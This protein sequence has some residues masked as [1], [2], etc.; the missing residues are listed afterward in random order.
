MTFDLFGPLPTGTTVLE[1]SAGTGKTYTIVGL[2]TR[3]VA[4]GV[5]SISDLLLVTFSRAATLELRERTRE[6]FTATATALADPAG[7]REHP[8]GVVRHLATGTDEDVRERRERLVS[9]LAD[10]DAGT[11]VTTHSFCQRM[12]DGLGVAGDRAPD[13]QFVETVDD[14]VAEV[15]GDIYLRAY[16]KSDVVPFSEKDALALARD[17]VG[18]A[19]SILEP[20][21]DRETEWG[22]RVLFADAVRREVSARKQRGGIRD[23][24]DLLVLLHAVVSDPESGESACRRIRERYRVVL[25]DEFQ[26]TDPLQWDILRRAFHEHTTLVLVGDP[27]QAIYA[28]R[29]AEVLSYLDAVRH[30]GTHAELTANW[31]TDAPLVGALE[32]VY[33]GAALGHPEIVVRPVLAVRTESA[34]PGGAPLQIRVLPR[35]AARARP[36]PNGFPPVA[37]MRSA[38]ASDVASAMLAFLRSGAT[39]ERNGVARS[40]EPGDIAVLVR[41]RNQ[42][43]LVR[44]ALDE[45]GIPSV[46]AGGTSVFATRS[47]REWSWVLRALEQPYRA[48]RVRLAALTPLFGWSAADLDEHRD[49]ALALIG[50]ELR[51]LAALFESTGFAAVFETLSARSRLD[52]RMLAEVAGERALTDLRHIAQVLGRVALENDYGV[53][54][55]ARWLGERIDE[56]TMG[57]TGD[58]S[59]RLDSDAAAVQIATVHASKGLEFPIVYVPFAWDAARH[60]K[61][62]TL[63]LHSEDGRRVLD[64]GGPTAP[65]YRERRSRAEAEESGEELR[66]LYVALTRAKS[67]VVAWWA[68]VSAT[69]R[70]ALQRV[71][72]GRAAG[73]PDV[74]ASAP[75]PDDRAVAQ[76]FAARVAD[77][78][79][80]IEVVAGGAPRDDDA[81]W[82]SGGTGDDALT[83]AVFTRTLDTAWRRTSYSALTAAAHDAPVS[84]PEV[85]QKTDEPEEAD[86][87]APRV[88]ADDV[89]DAIPSPLNDFPGGT[90]FGT[91]VHEILEYVDTSAA[92]LATELTTHCR[93]AVAAHLA[94]VDPDALATGL[95][96]VLHT[97]LGL[98]WA[99]G[100][101]LADV[102]PRDRLAELDFEL[103]LAGGLVPTHGVVDLG[104]VAATLRRRLPGTDVL[105]HYADALDALDTA[106]IRGFLTGSIDAVLRVGGRFVVVDY[107]TNRLA[108]DELTTA[109]YTRDRMTEAMVHSHYPLQALIYSVALHR[110]LRQRLPGY[111]PEEHLGGCAYLFVRGMAGPQTPPECGVYGWTPPAALVTEL[112]DVLAGKVH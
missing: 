59:R 71:L 56:P 32:H 19:E 72:F 77:A 6:R 102:A 40:V 55:L 110:Y 63:L 36:A 95:L 70:S 85:P 88:D 45:V 58:R 84:E 33:G 108:P 42:I 16:A 47:A 28:F 31:R 52:E 60:P 94:P 103:P 104:A 86:E 65:G 105:A 23:F 99:P 78:H 37:A 24:D 49:D 30:A 20:E 14:L 22:Q 107:K 12:L 5:A 29:G 109:H 101:A 48:D 35:S 61:P 8:D 112:S 15:V 11:I 96:P 69:S 25:I 38:V 80:A 62:A 34:C 13:V 43:D 66:L 73:A 9:A 7:A 97:P 41:T 26:D 87:L 57:T 39:I 67:R 79:G 98:S 89:V 10:F 90:A 100:I 46:L 83:A 75:V 54:E 1:A 68:P 64:V 81:R 21:P 18:D 92:D 53:A 17:A 2:A 4:E 91:L 111:L 74:E 50:S 3:Y 82:S 76:L 93:E 106:P 27:K 51:E 44:D